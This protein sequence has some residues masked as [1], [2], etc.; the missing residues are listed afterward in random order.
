M[1]EWSYCH[2]CYAPDGAKVGL[3]YPGQEVIVSYTDRNGNLYCGMGEYSEEIRLVTKEESQ[4]MPE[5]G[6]QFKIKSFDIYGS[7]ESAAIPY[8]EEHEYYIQHGNQHCFEF[9]GYAWK[10]VGDPAEAK[11]KGF[12]NYRV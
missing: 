10:P 7:D 1:S 9:I 5:E 12:P 4:I 11:L 2:E 8:D 6:I 3:P